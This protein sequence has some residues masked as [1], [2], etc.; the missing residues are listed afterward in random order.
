MKGEK[1]DT[2]FACDDLPMPVIIYRRDNGCLLKFNKEAKRVFGLPVSGK[3]LNISAIR[4]EK[5]INPPKSR[6]KKAVDFGAVIHRTSKGEEIL[7]RV[8]RKPIHFEGADCFVDFLEGVGAVAIRN[9]KASA[10]LSET[11]I[12][13]KMG[14]A[15]LDLQ[16]FLLTVSKELFQLLDVT[17]NE[18]Q[19]VPVEQFLKTYIHP[20]FLTEVLQKIDEGM[21]GHADK[22]KVVNTAFEMIT[23]N[24]RRIWVKAMGIF[25]G[26]T[27]LGILHDVTEP[28]KAQEALVEANQLFERLA[29]NVPGMI[30]K[31]QLK[32]ESSGQ[33]L[34]AS[35]GC[36]SL[37]GISAEKVKAQGLA[38]IVHPDDLPVIRQTM[39]DGFHNDLPWE[40]EF[41]VIMPNGSLKWIAGASSP[42]QER[43]GE[44]CW[45][46]FMHDVTG[47]KLAELKRIEIERIA[48]ENLRA[49]ETEMEKFHS[50]VGT[51]D[52]IVWEADARTFEFKFVSKQAE[53]I[54]GYPVSDWHT[55]PDFWANRIHPED[56]DTAV[57]FCRLSTS[58]LRDHDFEYR[59]ITREGREVWVQDKVAVIHRD[60]KPILLRGI[61][62]DITAHKITEE[63]IRK[64]ER[65]FR[66]LYN[67]TPVMMHSIEVDGK[68]S[69]VSDYWLQK[70]EYSREEVLGRRSTEFMTAE[71]KEKSAK[72]LPNFI[73]SGVANNLEFDFVTKSGKVLNTLLSSSAEYDEQGNFTRSMTVVTDITETKKLGKR[74]ELANRAAR[75]GVWQIDFANDSWECDDKL[76]EI[77]GIG[78]NVL[79]R[80]KYWAIIHPDEREAK[81]KRDKL[82]LQSTG[83]HYNDEYRIIRSTDQEVRYIKSQGLFFRD[84]QGKP[85]SGVSVVYDQTQE[86]LAEQ[87]TLQSLREKE[88]LIK[89]VHHRIKNNLQLISSI[90]YLKL[91]TFKQNDIR[92]F[93][94]GLRQKIKSI[95]VLHERL[96][97]TEELDAVN[98]ADFLN[99]VLKDIQVSFYRPDLM[100]NAK[101]EILPVYLPSDVATYCGL[102][103]NELVTNAIKHAFPSEN[104]GEIVVRFLQEEGKFLLSVCD[105][106]IGLP[107]HVAPR[108]S[109]SFGM[110]L[111]YIFVQQLGGEFSI[112]RGNGTDFQIRFR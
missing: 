6:S 2:S 25:K 87:K 21:N 59:M 37:F 102:I 11:L 33:F 26:S 70:M 30:F 41:R 107:A 34:Y 81:I 79:T 45:F 73:R 101:R 71:S 58:E 51:I 66:L 55:Q 78:E 48:Q 68:L 3:A 106:G 17:V 22:K 100:V 8:F 54:L 89:E 15:E 86:K 63:E 29:D 1:S 65:R 43:N 56:R 28:A 16:T 23:A 9:E 69:R 19:T 83:S 82:L 5:L 47:R 36:E 103:V 93:L 12:F 50:L 4:S 94:E 67:N 10:N 90:V 62:L 88:T 14:S 75:L 18:P 44:Y 74:L 76:R 27:A 77:F 20:D 39:K 99:R 85:L 91:S 40:M 104:K 64:S 110:S 112:T 98:I 84:E 96:L 46:G 111:I 52:G 57:N 60:G 13:G 42:Y 61:M 53:K 80:E 35:H 105:N 109:G 95:A 108:S 72:N 24:G 49:L 32:D 97:Q 31:Y 38:H 7:L 92:E